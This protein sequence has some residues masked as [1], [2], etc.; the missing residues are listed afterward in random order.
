MPLKKFAVTPGFGV[1]GTLFQPQQ[2]ALLG[3]IVGDDAQI[4]MTPF[5]QLYVAVEEEKLE[6]IKAQLRTAGLDI[7]EACF[8]TKNLIACNFCRGEQEAGLDIAKTLDR[9]V[10]G[11]PVPSPIKIGYAGCALGTS[12]PLLKDISVVKMRDTFDLY[13]GGEAKGLK[14]RLAKLLFSGLTADQLTPVLMRL[15]QDYQQNGKK[16]ETYARYT[17]RITLDRLRNHSRNGRERHEDH[18]N[19]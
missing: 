1:G 17:D 6:D 12:E 13:V 10:A 4:E 19:R 11:H 9:A 3:E 15:I 16:K 18:F 14:A 7:Q 2:L 5:K 8:Y